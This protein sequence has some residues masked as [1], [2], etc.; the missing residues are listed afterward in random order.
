MICYGYK[1]VSIPNGAVIIILYNYIDPFLEPGGG[2]QSDSSTS[3][4][5]SSRVKLARAGAAFFVTRIQDR[6]EDSP[7]LTLS[8]EVTTALIIS[9]RI[10][11]A[12]IKDHV[13]SFIESVAGSS[14]QDITYTYCLLHSLLNHPHY[15]K[16]P[17]PRAPNTLSQADP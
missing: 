6:C 14:N 3:S 12:L 7:Y 15:A 8:V 5:E 4:P 9:I 1:G 10:T 13:Q 17:S 11:D 16:D 2:K